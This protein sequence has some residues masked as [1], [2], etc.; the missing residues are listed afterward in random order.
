MPLVHFIQFQNDSWP[1]NFSNVTLV[2]I[3]LLF[4]KNTNNFYCPKI[5]QTYSIVNTEARKLALINIFAK[6]HLPTIFS[7]FPTI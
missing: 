2:Q 4:F 7:S 6:I 3:K 5:S 1:S